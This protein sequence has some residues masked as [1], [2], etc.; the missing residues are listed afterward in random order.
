MIILCITY[1]YLIYFTGERSVLKKGAFPSSFSFRPQTA[2][3]RKRKDQSL[4]MSIQEVEN[5]QMEVTIESDEVEVPTSIS[6][7]GNNDMSPYIYKIQQYSAHCLVN[8]LLKISN[9]TVKLFSITPALMIIIN[10][11]FSIIFLG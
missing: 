5:V 3:K 4:Y 1:C 8:F 9:M 10:S 6:S 2:T 11:C 7:T